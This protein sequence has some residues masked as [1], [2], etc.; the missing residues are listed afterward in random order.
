MIEPAVYRRCASEVE[1]QILRAR[2]ALDAYRSFEDWKAVKECEIEIGIL[3]KRAT[4]FRRLAFLAA[5]WPILVALA[6]VLLI[7][8]LAALAVLA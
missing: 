7:A 8:A 1:A 5:L 6:V 4:R 2:R 3:V